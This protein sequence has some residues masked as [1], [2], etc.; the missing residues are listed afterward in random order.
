MYFLVHRLSFVDM[1]FANITVPQMLAHLLST[2]KAIPFTNCLAQLFFAL[3]VGPMEGYLLAAMAYDHYVAIFDPLHYVTLVSHAL[4]LRIIVGSG[5]VVPGSTLLNIVLMAHLI[6]CSH[7]ILQFFCDITHMLQLYCSHAFLNEMLNFTEGK[8]M[9]LRPA[10]SASEGRECQGT[11][12]YTLVMPMLNPLIYSLRNHEVQGALRRLT[13]KK[14][15]S[16]I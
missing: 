7:G 11:I 1:V 3:F 9:Y 14:A 13:S 12:F 16:S 2:S 8:R 4:C 5:I 10:A 6:V 15:A